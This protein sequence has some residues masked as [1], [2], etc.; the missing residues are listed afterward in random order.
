MTRLRTIAWLIAALSLAAS[1]RAQ[2]A[3]GLLDEAEFGILAHDIPIGGDHREQGADFNG[4]ALFV[5]P[6]L[7]APIW[8]PRP[9]LGISINSAGGNSYAYFGLTWTANFT[10]FLLRRSGPGRRRA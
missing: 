6:G 10:E 9:H 5:S 7:L 1:G 3:A 2:A 4:E 8:A